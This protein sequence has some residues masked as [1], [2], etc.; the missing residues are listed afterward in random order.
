MLNLPAKVT[1]DDAHALSQ[2]LKSQILTHSGAVVVMA[3]QLREFDSSALAVLLACRRGALAAG[4][5]F[6]VRG[7]PS[8]LV[9]LATLYGVAQLVG[10]DASTNTA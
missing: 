1:H 4:K 5:P 3:D 10:S 7:L 8:K 2:S 6:S 9:Q